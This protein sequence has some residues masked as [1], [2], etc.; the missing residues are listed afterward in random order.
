MARLPKWCRKFSRIDRQPNRCPRMFHPCV[1]PLE[2]R[3]LLSLSVSYH[4]GPLMPNVQVET[5]YLG[6]AWADHSQLEP[7]ARQLD[8]F[9]SSITNSPFMDMLGQYNVGRGHFLGTDTDAAVSAGGSIDDTQI[10]GLLSQEIGAGHLASPTANMLYYVFTPPGTEVT[11]NGANSVTGVLG[12]HQDYTDA[13]GNTVIYAVIPYPGAPNATLTNLGLNGFQQ[14]T[15]VSSH[16]LAEAVTDPLQNAWYDD[17]RTTYG[18]EIGDLAIAEYNYAS[19]VFGTVDGYTVQ[20]EWS[21]LDDTSLLV[22]NPAPALASMS[23]GQI[24]A[25]HSS[26]LTVTLT[27]SGFI[28]S[29]IVNWNSSALTTSYVSSTKL[30]ATIPASDFTAAGN[31]QITVSNPTPA[32]GTSKGLTFQVHTTSTTTTVS[33]SLNP[34]AYSQSINLTASVISVAAGTGTPTGVVTFYDGTTKIGSGTLDRT[35][36]AT[37]ATK[38][39]SVGSHA[40]TAAYGGNVNFTTSSSTALTQT[41]QQDGTTTTAASSQNSSV[42]GEAVTFTATVK[43]TAPG[44]ANPT[45]VVTFYDGSTAIGSASLAAGIATFKTAKLAAGQHT[46]TALFRGNV[47][48]ATSASSALTQTVQQDG[49]TTTIASS[50]DPSAFGESIK[51]TATIKSASPGGGTPTGSVTFYDG[52]TA[53]GSATL[54]KSGR[55]TFAT[56]SLAAGSHAITAV[57]GGDVNFATSGSTSLTQ[58]V[59]ADNTITTIASSKATSVYG[60][61]VTFTA[62]VKVAAPGKG[63]PTGSIT[64]TD[65]TTIF[66]IVPLDSTGTAAFT[67]SS[68][69]LGAHMIEAS[70]GGGLGLAPSSS[71]VLKDTINQDGTKSVVVSSANPSG[72]GQ[73]VTFMATVSAATPGS[74][75]PT[76]TVT[77]YDGKVI[78]GTGTLSGGTV[79]LTTALLSS[80]KHKIKVVYGGDID[81]K[82]STSAVL[83]Q[84]INSSSASAMVIGAEGVLSGTSDRPIQAMAVAPLLL[85]SPAAPAGLDQ[86]VGVL[87]SSSPP[88]LTSLDIFTSGDGMAPRSDAEV[89]DSG[90]RRS[91]GESTH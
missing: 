17:V 41:V 23:P 36:H 74:G 58:T 11:D 88:G 37:F 60:E 2:D 14:L 29:S 54:D 84:V 69:S 87:N 57:Y 53:I 30:T 82:S 76:G 8:G 45:G 25:G 34:S 49:T 56:G 70:Y 47:N 24:E 83:N 68:L 78:L 12:Y 1:G 31:S 46:I 89:G 6:Q 62:K 80:G 59:E 18:A 50:K 5:L 3:Q 75:T 77:F 65:G 51:F 4:G 38:S 91:L 39:L 26:P 44:S 61:A 40:I 85:Q 73:A 13:S 20:R 15:G 32:G 71:K 79:S 64:F 28:P 9:F 52:S 48:F 81:F 16:E 27:G 7:T 63:I 42:Y 35:G 22:G 33:S 67:T 66:A 55:A 72:R 90:S 10:H 86:A 21:N 19:S 43:G